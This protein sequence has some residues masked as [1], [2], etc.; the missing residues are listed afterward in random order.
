MDQLFVDV[1]SKGGVEGIFAILFIWLFMSTR[2]EAGA[3]EKESREREDKLISHLNRTTETL[4]KI[5]QSILSIP[6]IEQSISGMKEEIKDIR[7]K[8]EK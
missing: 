6:V 3:R 1:M 8:I 4:Q 2:K 7:K 5:E